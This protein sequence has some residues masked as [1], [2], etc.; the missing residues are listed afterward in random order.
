MEQIKAEKMPLKQ[1]QER[2]LRVYFFIVRPQPVKIEGEGISTILSYDLDG[3]VNKAIEVIPKGY[4]V[5]IMGYRPM[6]EFLK[7]LQLDGK[8]VVSSSPEIEMP[9]EKTTLQQ[10]VHGLSLAADEYVKNPE[11]KKKLKQIIKE[12]Q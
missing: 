6:E 7:M 3:A 4:N 10:F 2:D 8:V 12:I 5:Q 1:S 9:K 11:S